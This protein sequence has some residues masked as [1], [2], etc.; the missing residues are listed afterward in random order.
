[1]RNIKLI[2]G[3]D[4]SSF[5]GWGRQPGRRTVQEALE[6]ALTLVMGEP[7]EVISASRT[8]RGV[9]ARGQTVNFLTSA[10]IPVKKIRQAVNGVLPPDISVKS[11]SAVGAGFNSRFGARKKVYSY[12]IVA[13]EDVS[14][15]VSRFVWHIKHPLDLLRIKKA[16]G[17]LIGK[18]D[19]SSFAVTDRRR[20]TR[21]SVRRIFSIRSLSAPLGNFYG[22]LAGGLRSK[23]LRVEFSGDG[24]LYKMVRSMVGTL[25]DAGRG[26]IGPDEIRKILKGKRRALAGRTAPPQGLMLEKVIY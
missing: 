16:A 7:I 17:K 14:P 18:H 4:G 19:F 21:S 1:M 24:F 8:D 12:T 6:K 23:A 2:I 11:A 25:V 13:G 22:D 9:H 10:A 20:K 26:R 5:F 3:Y 15:H